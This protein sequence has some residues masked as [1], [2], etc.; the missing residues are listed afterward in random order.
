MKDEKDYEYTGYNKTLLPVAK[1]LRK[2]M[3][4]HERHLWYDFLQKHPVKFYKQRP[5]GAYVA[6]FYCSDAKLVIELDGNQHYTV[7]GKEK[8]EMRTEVLETYDLMVLRISNYDL[9][10]NFD[11][12]CYEIDRIVEERL[13]NH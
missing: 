13:K 9:D 11:G 12:V 2:T 10:K 8:D 4:R 7:H 3:T 1:A 6:D 5:I